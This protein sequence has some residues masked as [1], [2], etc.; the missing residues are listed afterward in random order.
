ME[1]GLYTTEKMTERQVEDMAIQT[2]LGFKK[3]EEVMKH[4]CKITGIV[5]CCWKSKCVWGWDNS[6][7]RKGCGEEMNIYLIFKWVKSKGFEARSPRL[8]GGKSGQLGVE[9]ARTLSGGENDRKLVI[10]G[11]E[12]IG[13]SR[14]IIYLCFICNM[15][16]VFS[17]MHVS[18]CIISV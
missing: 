1:N 13:S 2:S 17:Y 14:I 8:R 15:S 10:L 12:T 9:V 18:T 7:P 4:T 3:L 5:N 11:I 6:F 16:Y